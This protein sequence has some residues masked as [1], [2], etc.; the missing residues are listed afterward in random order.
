M[1]ASHWAFKIKMIND[2]NYKSC[3]EIDWDAYN[4]GYS[5]II[6]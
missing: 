6:L 1:T 4:A 2:K 5:K 3:C